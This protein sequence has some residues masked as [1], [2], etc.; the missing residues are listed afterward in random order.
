MAHLVLAALLAMF[1]HNPQR[2]CMLAR[3][4]AIAEQADAAAAHWHVPAGLLLVVGFLETHDGC[5][6]GEG[7]GWGSPID[8]R[9]RHTAGT[10]D[11]T[12]RGLA[13]SYAACGTWLGALHRYRV[14][15]CNGRERV[16]Y[17]AETAWRLFER[18]RLRAGVTAPEPVP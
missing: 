2:A 4:D 5:D 18:V 13:H 1:P 10:A 17:S 14:G 11:S 15:L 8:R 16:G 12:A 6:A 3:A 9:H 7:G